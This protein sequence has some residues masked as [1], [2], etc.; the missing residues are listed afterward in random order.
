MGGLRPPRSRRASEERSRVRNGSRRSDGEGRRVPRRG[1][2]APRKAGQKRSRDV[3]GSVRRAREAAVGSRRRAG[4]AARNAA[5]RKD[6]ALGG[7]L[8]SADEPS[9]LTER[10]GGSYFL[11]EL[12]DALA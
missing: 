4:R 9:E 8:Q 2:R 3:A 1:P 7:C 5:L 12:F 6:G 10:G 11:S